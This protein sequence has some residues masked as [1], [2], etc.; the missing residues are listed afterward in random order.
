MYSV[1][2][3]YC[4][5][6]NSLVRVRRST[7]DIQYGSIIRV[8]D[9]CGKPYIDKHYVEAFLSPNIKPKVYRGGTFSGL[10]VS[11][12][13]TFA[14]ISNL[15]IGNTD[16]ISH[17][18]GILSTLFFILVVVVMVKDKKNYRYK[19]IKYQNEYNASKERL[20]NSSYRQFLLTNGYGNL[21]L[22]AGII[23]Q[24]EANSKKI[25]NDENDQETLSFQQRNSS[26]NEKSRE[27]DRYK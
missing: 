24:E 27:N 5:N 16:N 18:A 7:D 10:F 3:V 14:Y 13:L 4:P 25:I 6:C 22:Q 8:C 11:G 9:H 12:L 15:I 20:S 21:L 17:I 2:Q 1:Y 23:S 26:I 19:L